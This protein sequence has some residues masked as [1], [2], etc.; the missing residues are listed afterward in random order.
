MFAFRPELEFAKL[1]GNSSN[2][3][4]CNVPANSVAANGYDGSLGC[5]WRIAHINKDFKLCP[6]Y[7]AAL[8]VPKCITDEQIVQSATF[9]DG[10]RFPVLCYRHEN[11]VSA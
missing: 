8:I 7:G 10:G 2:V 6:T 11:G 4:T 5:E 1:V 9:R 3:G